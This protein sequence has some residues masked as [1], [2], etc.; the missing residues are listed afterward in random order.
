LRREII[1]IPQLDFTDIL[2]TMQ[3]KIKIRIHKF[4]LDRMLDYC[5][6]EQFSPDGDEY[7]IV[8]FPFIGDEY[9]YNI[10]LGFGDKRERLEPPD[11][12]AEMKRRIHSIAALYEN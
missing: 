8:S 1:K 6:H 10:L 3:T 4:V 5:A 2:E 11:I 12:R 9:Y 7:Y